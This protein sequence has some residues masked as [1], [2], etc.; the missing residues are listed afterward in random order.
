MAPAACRPGGPSDPGPAVR[1]EPEPAG[2]VVARTGAREIRADE[3]APLC[4]VALELRREFSLPAPA[5]ATPTEALALALE[6]VLL[7]EAGADL[8]GDG[9][10]AEQARRALARLYLSR[11]IEYGADRPAT[12]EELD[13]ALDEEI[14]RYSSTSSSEFYRPSRVS[15]VMLLVGL[16]PDMMPPTPER[17]ARIGTDE[18]RALAEDFRKRCGERMGDEDRF[19][20]LAREAFA[21]HPTVRLEEYPSVG[22]DARMAG[23]LHPALHAALVGLDGCGAVSP[24]VPFDG[25][26]AVIRRGS[27]RPGRNETVEEA[28]PFLQRKLTHGRRAE[29]LR[30][31]L[32]RA[33]QTRR[34]QTFPERLPAGE[35][36]P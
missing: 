36:P 4:A 13:R 25:G 20:A 29:A 27:F 30:Q 16:R 19:R 14:R 5:P 33:R 9:R 18:A 34:I 23:S 7:A 24:V 35:T 32:D 2:P 31:A 10:V 8:A 21:G 12:A 11:V 6:P 22:L 17:P 26:F 3:I 1:R 15:A 28:R